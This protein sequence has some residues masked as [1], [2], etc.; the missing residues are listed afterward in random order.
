M[1]QT[2]RNVRTGG[3]CVSAQSNKN[4][5]IRQRVSTELNAA[6]SFCHRARKRSI[7]PTDDRAFSVCVPSSPVFTAV[8][9]T[10]PPSSLP[11]HAHQSARFRVLFPPGNYYSTSNTD[12]SGLAH[13]LCSFFSVNSSC[14]P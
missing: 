8:F 14:T 4:C 9:P 13:S 7:L 12:T 1:G 3:Y 6:A 2:C 10:P 11:A 5:T